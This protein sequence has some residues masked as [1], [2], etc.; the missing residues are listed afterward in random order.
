MS[1]VASRPRDTTNRGEE[2]RVIRALDALPK[3][4]RR[5]NKVYLDG[6]SAR[7]LLPSVECQ[8]WIGKPAS[9]FLRHDKVCVFAIVCE[10]HVG[11]ADFVTLANAQFHVDLTGRLQS[12]QQQGPLP[13][14]RTVHAY[15]TG[16]LTEISDSGT[17]PGDVRWKP[18]QY[19]PAEYSSFRIA[20]DNVDIRHSAIVRLTPGRQKVWALIDPEGSAAASST[21][22]DCQ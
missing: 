22:G 16:T 20:G 7:N 21:G 12:N 11:M 1:T 19:L 14:R 4:I 15:L 2:N 6:I 8:D 17:V 10:D 3:S 5:L 9:V 13:N 18:V